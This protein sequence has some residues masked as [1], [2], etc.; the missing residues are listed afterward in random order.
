MNQEQAGQKQVEEHL[1]RVA[2]AALAKAK[3]LGLLKAQE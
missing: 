1:E 3:A 2:Q